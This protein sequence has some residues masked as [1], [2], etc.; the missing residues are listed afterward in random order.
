MGLF[1]QNTDNF[2]IN[3]NC[4]L[5][6]FHYEVEVEIE[7]YDGN[8]CNYS[9]QIFVIVIWVYGHEIKN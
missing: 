3:K 1:I 8:Y 9:F 7:I 5:W 4:R 2:E 6:K